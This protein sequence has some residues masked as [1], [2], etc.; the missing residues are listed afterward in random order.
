MSLLPEVPPKEWIRSSQGM[1]FLNASRHALHILK[2]WHL[3]SAASVESRRP[4]I[5]RLGLRLT[6]LLRHDLLA[7]LLE[8]HYSLY[9]SQLATSDWPWYSALER[10]VDY[11]PAEMGALL[12]YLKRSAASN[13]YRSHWCLQQLKAFA[14][15]FRS[16][17]E[18]DNKLKSIILHHRSKR[19]RSAHQPDAE[20]TTPS[21][22]IPE[23]ETTDAPNSGDVTVVP[24]PAL[25]ATTEGSIHHP[26][27]SDLSTEPGISR[28]ADV[29]VSHPGQNHLNP[30]VASGEASAMVI[31]DR[32]SHHTIDM[33]P[34]VLPKPENALPTNVT[35]TT[36]GYQ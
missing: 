24:G 1:L 34:A 21:N 35:R 33:P 23:N 30:D 18:A 6:K 13:W 12:Q 17:S 14:E 25:A 20:R 9:P 4:E 36:A 27:V 31:D 5:T 16:N 10:F 29:Q 26:G 8:N 19:S 28:L 22:I 7:A 15:L 2:K 32:V 3:R 11:T